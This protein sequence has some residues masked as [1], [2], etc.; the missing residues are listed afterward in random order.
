MRLRPFK[1]AAT[2]IAI[3][4]LA[5]SLGPACGHRGLPKPPLPRMPLAPSETVWRQR[6]DFVE[7]RARFSLVGLQGRPLR[8]PAAP[9]VSYFPASSEGLAAGWN[10]KARV[11]EFTRVASRVNATPFSEDELGQTSSR[12]ISL[13]LDDLGDA[14]RFVLAL[15]LEDA[16]SRSLPSPRRILVPAR[17][18]LPPLTGVHVRP[19]ETGVRLTWAPPPDERVTIVRIYRSVGGVGDAW[20][21]WRT[22]P[23]RDGETF[24]ESVAYGQ[25]VAYALASAAETGEVAV[26]S[27]P[28]EPGE[29]VY[30]DVYPPLPPRDLDAVAETGRVRV[31]WFEGGSEDEKTVVVERQ[32]EGEETFREVGGVD[33]PDAWFEDTDVTAD[34][35]YR[36]RAYG[37]DDAGNRSRN[38][39]PTGWVSPRRSVKDP[40]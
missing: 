5:V 31:F 1:E 36:Y 40:P 17:P 4:L 24:D 20:K 22:A 37:L 21:P 27:R 29:L 25:R 10:S 16:R 19:E 8:P 13:P 30:A 7:V 33:V 12:S 9:V 35:R 38:A 2:R 6:G 11:R 34:R 18:A 39:G 3:A 15:G 26:E 32:V 14:A 28:V 23:A